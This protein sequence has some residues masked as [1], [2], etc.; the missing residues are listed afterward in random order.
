MV[1]QLPQGDL[2]IVQLVELEP[3]DPIADF[4]AADEV[5][6]PPA[7]LGPAVGRLGTQAQTRCRLRTLQT[8][9][10]TRFA[11]CRFASAAMRDR[12]GWEKRISPDRDGRTAAPLPVAAPTRTLQPLT[13]PLPGGAA[14]APTPARARGGPAA[15]EEDRVVVGEEVAEL[16]RGAGLDPGRTDVAYFVVRVLGVESP[17]VRACLCA[18]ALACVRACACMLA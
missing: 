17:A 18:C 8:A 12:R 1:S 14:G 10:G 9:C 6:S 11:T 7:P 3:R 16:L 5:P 15:G 2:T 4:A 13:P